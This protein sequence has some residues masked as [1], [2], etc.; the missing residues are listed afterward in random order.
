[1]LTADEAHGV[2]IGQI[3]Q[4][5]GVATTISAP[6]RKAIICGLIDTPPNTVS[7]LIGCGR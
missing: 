4:P 2:V 6:P 1:M 5:A 3:E 7:T